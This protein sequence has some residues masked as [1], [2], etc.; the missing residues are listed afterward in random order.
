MISLLGKISVQRAQCGGLVNE[1]IDEVLDILSDDCIGEYFFVK[2]LVVDDIVVV[3]VFGIITLETV[4]FVLDGKKHCLNLLS[5]RRLCSTE[6][7]HL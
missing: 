5:F 6:L 4:T 1:T 2:P 7:F 3:E